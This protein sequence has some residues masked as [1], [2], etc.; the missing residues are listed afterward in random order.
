M[1]VCVCLCGAG[2]LLLLLWL[3]VSSIDTPAGPLRSAT[4]VLDRVR[5]LLLD[6]DGWKLPRHA[7]G[8]GG[9]IQAAKRADILVLGDDLE[10]RAW[11]P[12]LLLRSLAGNP[13]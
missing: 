9:V 4:I 10:P 2:R 8:G 3:L 7:P 1:Y 5:N 13:P 11:C 12:G 6:L